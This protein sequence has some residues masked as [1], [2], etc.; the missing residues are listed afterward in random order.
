MHH[1]I[2]TLFC[3]EVSLGTAVLPPV[4][5]KGSEIPWS[6]FFSQQVSSAWGKDYHHLLSLTCDG[7]QSALAKCRAMKSLVW[8]FSE[9]VNCYLAIFEHRSTDH[10][11]VCKICLFK[12]LLRLFRKS[13][14]VTSPKI[15][16]LIGCTHVEGLQAE[17]WKKKIQ[18]RLFYIALHLSSIY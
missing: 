3:F 4:F 8:S 6:W 18:R 9:L 12:C 2:S 17:I 16:K 10:L 13:A 11:Q 7:C 15:V 5:Y 1:P 14:K